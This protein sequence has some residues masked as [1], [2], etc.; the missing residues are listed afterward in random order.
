MCNNSGD[1]PIMLLIY[2]A[3]V[4]INFKYYAQYYAHVS[5]LCLGINHC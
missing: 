4:F 5:D 1:Q 3:A 2:Y